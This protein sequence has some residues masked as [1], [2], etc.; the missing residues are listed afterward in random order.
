MLLNKGAV[1]DNIAMTEFNNDPILAENVSS[2]S[3]VDIPKGFK[4]R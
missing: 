3:I 1:Y 4:V 2:V